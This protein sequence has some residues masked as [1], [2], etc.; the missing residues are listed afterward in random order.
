MLRGHE[1]VALPADAGDVENVPW[2]QKA[3]FI[4]SGPLEPKQ[5]IW[6]AE[7]KASGSAPTLDD[8]MQH[9]LRITLTPTVS[10]QEVLADT[11]GTW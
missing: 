6:S 11:A 9:S 5:E 10:G 3:T 1:V 8:I 7:R 4:A 2:G